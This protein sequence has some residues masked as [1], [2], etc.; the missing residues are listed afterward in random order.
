[1]TTPTYLTLGISCLSL[2]VATIAAWLSRANALRTSTVSW[3]SAHATRTFEALAD[4]LTATSPE[5]ATMGEV[6]DAMTRVRLT[7]SGPLREL[8]EEVVDARRRFGSARRLVESR[9]RKSHFRLVESVRTGAAAAKEIYE[10]TGDQ[11]ARLAIE[12]WNSL[13]SFYSEVD[14]G[15]APHPMPVMKLLREAGYDEGMVHRLTDTAERHRVRQLRE[16]AADESA[17]RR[18]ALED[19]RS[20][21][22]DAV[23]EW[24]R[25]PPTMRATKR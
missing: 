11:D 19:T 6:I 21:L 16:D 9:Q 12:A 1:M 25:K 13:E 15:E 7:A 10:E 4:L 18:A 24:S 17:R 14:D 20:R 8:A 3:Q 22:V 23:S 5:K 2:V